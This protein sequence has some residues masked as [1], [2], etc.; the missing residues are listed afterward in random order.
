MSKE[1]FYRLEAEMRFI[2]FEQDR[3]K[4]KLP[5]IVRSEWLYL[6]HWLDGKSKKVF[7][8]FWLDW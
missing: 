7:Y 4:K 1:I 2:L 5:T 6:Y 3:G 8:E